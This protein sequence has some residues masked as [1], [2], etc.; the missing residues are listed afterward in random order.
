MLSSSTASKLGGDDSGNV[1]VICRFRPLNSKEIAR[2]S[3]EWMDYYQ[4]SVSSKT[5][6][7]TPQNFNFDR[8]FGPGTTQLQIYE[9]V[10]PI[11]LDVLTGYNAT[12]F[13]YGQT[14]SGKTHT[15]QGP[16]ITDVE[17]QGVIPRMVSTIFSGIE[18]SDESIEFVLKASYIEIYMEKIRDL[19]E[20]GPG[21][22]NLRVLEN[23][24]KGTSNPH[25]LLLSTLTLSPTHSLPYLSSPSLS[26]T[27]SSSPPST[28][29]II[30]THSPQPPH[31][32]LQ[33]LPPPTHSPSL[34]PLPL[35]PPSPTPPLSH[36]PPLLSLPHPPPLSH[37]SSTQEFLWRMHARSSS[38]SR[39][40]SISCLR[41]GRRIGRWH[42]RA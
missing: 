35:H 15:M 4:T 2:N 34:P 18:S 13:A 1:K 29:P 21:K 26:L 9:I 23:P 42:R 8:V 25:P 19:L 20:T 40:S 16:S 11:V 17:M 39:R 33:H 41:M 10:E 36:P 28:K 12:I 5:E 37:P 14:S 27:N 22:D 24:E 7:D 6:D 31:P 30:I 3:S 32:P 38:P